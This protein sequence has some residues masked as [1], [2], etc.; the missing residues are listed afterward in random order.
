MLLE[1][2]YRLGV[3]IHRV[4]VRPERI[5]AMVI[6][7]GNITTG[8]TG[9]TEFVIKIV[10]HLSDRNIAILSRG[11]RGRLETKGGVVTE[12]SSPE[13]VGDEPAMMAE[14]VNCPI[15]VGKDR[16]RQ[17]K[18]AIRNLGTDI[19]ILDDGFQ[20]R[21]LLYD[22]NI[23][24]INGRDPFGNNRLLPRG[25][26]REPLS[27]IGRADIIVVTKTET[28]DRALIQKI[29]EHN[30]S[31]PIFF[32][33]YQPKELLDGE[34]RRVP[35]SFLKG[36]SVLAV[37]S[38]A[39]PLHFE[40]MLTKLCQDVK[41]LRFPDHHWFRDEDIR[42]I[43]M[44]AF[45]S[46]MVVSTLKDRVKLKGKLP[47]F[48]LVIEPLIE[49]GFYQQISELTSHGRTCISSHYHKDRADSF[50]PFSSLV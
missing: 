24:L 19:F 40:E 46:D 10:E 26:L 41:P 11:Y 23:L 17:A 37:S 13:D 47:F 48:S 39:D 44:E 6:S 21:G 25:R 36:K 7:V 43:E 14:R 28:A 12:R 42:R 8:G 27:A 30:L 3:Q 31:A 5:P 20:Y 35:L 45:C 34:E 4:L 32:A 18:W 29:R 2:F 38:I 50:Q 22:I 9:K 49:E 1:S 33:K 16:R 15:I